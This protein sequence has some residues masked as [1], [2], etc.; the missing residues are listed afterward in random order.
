LGTFEYRARYYDQTVG[1][2]LSEDAYREGLDRSLYDYVGNNPGIF[3]DPSG[4]VARLYCDIIPTGRGR[5]LGQQVGLA[6]AHPTHC[7][8]YISCHGSGHY[9][10]LYGPPVNGK[11]G[12]PHNDQPLN[13][14]RID[15]SVERTLIPPPGMGC[16]EFEDRLEKA[17]E[18][19]A[20]HLPEYNPLGPNSNTFVNNIIR[21]AGGVGDLPFN[22]YGKNSGQ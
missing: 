9:L 11:Y 12:I 15:H 8:L 19:Q 22:A 6:I 14:D 13:L 20:S 3:V 10:E 4:L 16:C 2:F 7:Y 1:R 21:E 18:D 5:T 17:F